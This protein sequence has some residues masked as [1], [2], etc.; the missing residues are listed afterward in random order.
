MDCCNFRLMALPRYSSS[1]VDRLVHAVLHILVCTGNIQVQL[2]EQKEALHIG[3]DFP[4]LE[5]SR[6]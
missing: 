3:E 4:S 6:M 2:I 1:I 5:H